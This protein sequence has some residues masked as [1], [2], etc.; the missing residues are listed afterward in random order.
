[1]G[2]RTYDFKNIV[3]G[4]K[5]VFEKY[6]PV[7]I[8][9]V[10]IVFHVSFNIW[11]LSNHRTPQM[12]DAAEDISHSL[13]MFD[14]FREGN[15]R[16]ALRITEQYGP[17]LYYVTQPFYLFL[18]RSAMSAV[19]V[20]T[21]FFVLLIIATYLIGKEMFSDATGLLAAFL[22]SF[23]PQVFGMSRVYTPDFVLTA[24]I[25]F[26]VLFLLKSRGFTSRKYSMILGFFLGVSALVKPAFIIFFAGPL[27]VVLL[28][29]LSKSGW[30]VT[31][32]QALNILLVGVISLALWGLWLWSHH[33]MFLYHARVGVSGSQQD[34]SLEWTVV[35]ILSYYLKSLFTYQLLY[36]FGGLFFLSLP[37]FFVGDIPPEKRWLLLSFFVLPSLFFAIVVQRDRTLLFLLPLAIG[38]GLISAAAVVGFRRRYVRA[39]LVVLI[40]VIGLVQFLVLHVSDFGYLSPPEARG[41]LGLKYFE[42]FRDMG[43]LLEFEFGI[44][45]PSSNSVGLD[46]VI[47]LLEEDATDEDKQYKILALN[48]RLFMSLPYLLQ[49]RQLDNLEVITLFPHETL[50]QYNVLNSPYPPDYF[51]RLVEEDFVHPGIAAYFEIERDSYVLLDSQSVRLRG[52]Y[53]WSNDTLELYRKVESICAE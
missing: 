20:N 18:G 53:E 33:D 4:D 15:I 36:F 9:A 8:L 34:Y 46:G 25:A 5:T 13:D 41:T 10:L 23:Y 32:A 31:G 24:L 51:L 49:L 45:R 7:L 30:R 40:V 26:D 6:I 27:L 22:V 12:E 19:L 38:I 37:F 29:A 44:F 28:F 43:P 35:E 21:L 11:I 48:P 16:A 39:A 1:M 17:V 50:E 42:S 3:V 2:R 14:L 52:I 47:D